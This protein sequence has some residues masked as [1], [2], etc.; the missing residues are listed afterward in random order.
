M[1]K[2]FSGMMRNATLNN[3]VL[4]VPGFD[5]SAYIEI[6]GI[7]RNALLTSQL[8]HFKAVGAHVSV[9]STIDPSF[10]DKIPGSDKSYAELLVTLDNLVFV[11]I[12]SNL[13]ITPRDQA[14]YAELIS[15]EKTVTSSNNAL[16][17]SGRGIS[18]QPLIL[19]E[20][21]I[22]WSSKAKNNTVNLIMR[23]GTG[24][25]D[26]KETYYA[27][28]YGTNYKPMRA[29]YDLTNVFTIRLYK[30]GD[31]HVKFCYKKKVDEEVLL[32]LLINYMESR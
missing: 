21:I 4:I 25:F 24:M 2:D 15:V 11:D 23:E 19:D 7:L 29:V 18:P 26:F 3:G 17:L 14:R 8:P 9:G 27:G 22:N 20:P 30:A 5:E 10:V 12:S 16:I 28:L 6:A 1:V 13:T 31:N 32:K